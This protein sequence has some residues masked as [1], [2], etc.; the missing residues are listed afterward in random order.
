MRTRHVGTQVLGCYPARGGRGTPLK[1]VGLLRSGVAVEGGGCIFE[2]TIAPS[3]S[4]EVGA[5][6]SE[7]LSVFFV[8]LAGAAI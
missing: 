8:L 4:V 5:F 1:S 2:L 6:V 7:A 3:L